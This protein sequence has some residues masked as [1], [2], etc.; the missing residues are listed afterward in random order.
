MAII[1]KTKDPEGLLSEIQQTLLDKPL[2]TWE[3]WNDEFITHTPTQWHLQAHFVG[4]PRADEQELRFGLIVPQD[5]PVRP[6]PLKDTIDVYPYYHGRF[7]S[8][9]FAHFHS[10]FTSLEAT[11]EPK[12]NIDIILR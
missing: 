9:L 4:Y 12:T 6:E 2:D 1:L 10:R 11:T 7:I 8:M 5:P 3:I